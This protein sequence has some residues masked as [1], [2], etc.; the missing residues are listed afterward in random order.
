MTITAKQQNYADARFNGASKKEAAIIAGC[1]D[2]TAS[3]AASRLEKHPHV[4]AYLDRMKKHDC[5]ITGGEDQN[6]ETSGVKFS[7][8]KEMLRYSMN[9]PL[10]DPK[11]RIQA[12][13]ALLP[14]EHHRLGEGGKKDKQ[15]ADAKE[16]SEGRFRSAKP[17][18]L[19]LIR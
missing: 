1:P 18:S 6:I 15:D 17:P 9:D 3:Q 14:Y 10:L 12:A 7:D 2:K 16:I 19:K 11:T 13:T 8:P 5:N 4:I